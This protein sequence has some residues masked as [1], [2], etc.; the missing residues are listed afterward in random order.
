MHNLTVYGRLLSRTIVNGLYNNCSTSCNS[1]QTNASTTNESEKSVGKLTPRLVSAVSGFPKDFQ[2]SKVRKGQIGDDA[3]LIKS[4]KSADI[5]GIMA[6]LSH[7]VK[8]NIP[9]LCL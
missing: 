9:A 4:S 2:S 7:S 1:N 8:I 3:W 6:W 5:L